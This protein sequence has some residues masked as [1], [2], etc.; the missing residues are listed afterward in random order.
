MARLTPKGREFLGQ[1]STFQRGLA[2]V[3]EKKFKAAFK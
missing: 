2:E 3:I 1:Y